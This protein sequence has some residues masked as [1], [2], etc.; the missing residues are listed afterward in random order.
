MTISRPVRISRRLRTFLWLVVVL[1]I[2]AG[3]LGGL[4]FRYW[5]QLHTPVELHAPQFPLIGDPDFNADDLPPDLRLWYDRLWAAINDGETYPNPDKAASSGDLYSIGRTLNAHITALLT[6][7]RIT[8]DLKLLDEVDRLMELTRGQLADWNGDG[9]LNWR[10]LRQEEKGSAYYN[11]DK[12]QMDEALAH[13]W[14]AEAAY[15][16]KINAKYNPRY[17]THADFWTDYLVNGFLAKWDARGGLKPPL[18]HPYAHLMR[19]YYYLYRLTNDEKYLDEASFRAT[20][21]DRMMDEKKTGHG[22]AYTWDHRVLGLDDPPWGCQPTVY[23]MLT[24]VAFQ[25]LALEGFGKYADEAYMTHYVVTF[26]ELVATHSTEK[27]AGNVCGDEEESFGKYTISSVP[28]L[29]LWDDTG[30]IAAISEQGYAETEVDD[31]P[32]RIFIPAYMLQGL[33]EEYT[34]RS[35]RLP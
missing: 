12:H 20:V 35:A 27:L 22:V 30:K 28:G 17:G 3:L 16:L 1:A 13:S 26:R 14:I 33:S 11:D 15:A 29:A 32:Q 25:D 23:G 6:A 7:F 2:V 8:G 18:T 9:Y 34:R 10:W 4:F 24:L 31:K 21:L 5:Q 19:F